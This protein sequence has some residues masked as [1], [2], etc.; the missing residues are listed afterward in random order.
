IRIQANHGADKRFA[1][2]CGRWSTA[3]KVAKELARQ[4]RRETMESEKAEKPSGSSSLQ[5]LTVLWI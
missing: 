3:W 1:M 5:R 4:E 2:L